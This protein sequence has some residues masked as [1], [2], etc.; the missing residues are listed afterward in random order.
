MWRIMLLA[1]TFIACPLYPQDLDIPDF[2]QGRQKW[3]ALSSFERPGE[4]W[5]A[6]GA[7]KAGIATESPHSGKANF[8]I[9]FAEGGAV[10]LRRPFL[11]HK[12]FLSLRLFVRVEE[13]DDAPVVKAQLSDGRAM[14]MAAP[15]DADTEL[16][17][18]WM[19][20]MLDCVNIQPPKIR[21]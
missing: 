9:R 2:L 1:V 4:G 17:G 16:G 12:S 10:R 21:G 19:P 20:Y 15:E 3:L 5:T 7:K 11:I 8:A 6:Y 18:E 13:G 14:K